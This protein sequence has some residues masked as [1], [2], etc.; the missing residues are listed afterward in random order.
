VTFGSETFLNLKETTEL[1]L[2]ELNSE[3]ARSRLLLSSSYFDMDLPAYFN[4]GPLL[5]FACFEAME[6]IDTQW[7]KWKPQDYADVNYSLLHN[8]DGE[9][10]WRPFEL[11]NP[12][13]YGR[14]VGL[15]TKPEN[16]ITIQNRIRDFQ[17]GIVECCS[18]PV[19]TLENQ[20]STKEQIM[21]WWKRVEQ[22]SLELS[23][24]YSHVRLTDVSNCYPSIY[25]HA[26]AWAI[27]DRDF[28]KMKENRHDKKLLGN[29]LDTLISSSRG[30]QTNGIPQASLLSHLLAEII[31][32]YCDTYI[33]K[34]LRDDGRVKI[35]R[36]RDDYR[37][38]GYSDT[39]CQKA[40]KVISEKLH[41]FGMKLGSVKTTGAVNVV[42]GAVKEDKI[43]AISL[44][45]RQTTLQKELLLIHQFS[46]SKPG[47]GA[48]KF[49]LSKFMDR[50]SWKIRRNRIG[51][52][53]I[54]VL[55][56]ILMDMASTSPHV[57]PAV[58]TAISEMMA[59][60]TDELRKN[61]FERVL[62]RTQRIPN[63]G[64]MET[65]LQRIAK[66]NGLDFFSADKICQQIQD[67]HPCLWNYDW[68]D[69]VDLRNRLAAYSVV[70]HS[71]LGM[72]PVQIERS[73][74]DSFWKGYD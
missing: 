13:I 65:W 20:R 26:I 35:L 25:S 9:I 12:L 10:G 59:T 66:P 61:L 69:D 68:V 2:N 50:L 54:T 21:N 33:D 19:V 55:T 1:Y 5:E 67:T 48:L 36:Y 14:C 6:V 47:S 8:K 73:E 74:F 53:N 7:S 11:I 4:F 63:S 27:H 51:E 46:Q 37:I 34:A 29:Q 32:G 31:L 15:I 72:L 52:E 62:R 30:G 56:S 58:A 49:L 39:D 17:G 3:E 41:M 71:K 57:F 40:L 22:R 24:E 44:N 70:D 28:I 38:F 16:W 45:L 60:L 42:S 23:L 64:Y 43:A 18:M